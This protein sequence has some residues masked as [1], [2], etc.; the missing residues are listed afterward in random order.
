MLSCLNVVFS[1]FPRNYPFA[2]I[3]NLVCF[4]QLAVQKPVDLANKRGVEEIPRRPPCLALLQLFLYRHVRD[5]SALL[6]CHCDVRV[7][8]PVKRTL[9]CG[10]FGVLVLNL[11]RVVRVHSPQLWPQCAHQWLSGLP[12]EAMAL[13]DQL[14][15]KLQERRQGP[16]LRIERL[17]FTGFGHGLDSYLDT[18][19]D[20]INLIYV[21]DK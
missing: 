5:S 6:S 9:D 3:R 4:R 13:G 1:I 10:R 2:F 20:I 21:Y 11:V 7:K 16:F 14:G 15:G 8:L 12:A 19:L 17:K 18:T